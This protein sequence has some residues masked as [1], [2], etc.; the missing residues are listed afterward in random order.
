[1][2]QVQNLITK[3]CIFP[4][5]PSFK[6]SKSLI[7]IGESREQGDLQH[8]SSVQILPSSPSARPS[9]CGTWAAWWLS[10]SWAGPCTPAPYGRSFTVP[11][12]K[13][14]SLMER[15]MSQEQ[16][17]SCSQKP[18]L[19]VPEFS[20]FNN[21]FEVDIKRNSL[22]LGFSIDGGPDAP[23]PWYDLLIS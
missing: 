5:V 12:Q 8:L 19:L 18:N 13:P 2:H 7:R 3:I 10:C 20:D 4:L 23:A 21:T 9:T 17:Q 14:L 16:S 1:M 11:Y 22:G 6:I 15:N